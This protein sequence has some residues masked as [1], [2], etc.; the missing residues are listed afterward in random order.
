MKNVAL[1]PFNKITQGIVR[2]RDLTDFSI[3]SIIDFVLNTNEDAGQ[4]IEGK[5][6]GIVITDNIEEAL[7]A[8]DTLILNDPG[9]SFG[10]NQGVYSQYNLKEL[11][12]TLVLSAHEKNVRVVSV[13][14]IFDEESLMWLQDHE[15]TIDVDPQ[16][17][18]S[19]EQ[20]LNEEY[21]FP[22]PEDKVSTY[23]NY[24]NLDNIMS[25]YNQNICK[26]GI[27]ATRGCLGKFTAQMTL[28]RE[29]RNAGEKVQAIISEPT[30]SLFNQPGGDIMKFISQKRLDQYPYYINA[31]VR[32]AE[33]N[34]NDFVLLSGQGSLLPNHNFVIAAT[35]TSYLRAFQP[36]VTLLVVG[37]DDDEEIQDC[38]DILRIY[39]GNR[40]KPFALLIPD[41]IEMDFNQYIIKTK[42]EIEQRKEY[43]K[44]TFNVDHVECVLDISQ[45]TGKLI[46]RKLYINS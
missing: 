28:F 44:Y 31:A 41:K 11:W 16:I 27:F 14:E 40:S 36:D 24:F 45:L 10:N 17:P 25:N 15:I 7:S 9:T 22:S 32:E 39:G 1:Y 3:T 4:I 37:Y 35:K 19:L 5:P 8:V 30:A 23:L 18:Y 46:E 26:V 2:F 34:D 33:H 13:H 29:L 20:R 42:E 12:R 21:V 6:S 43:L 38:M